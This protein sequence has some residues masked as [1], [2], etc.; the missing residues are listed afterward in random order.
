M[1][2]PAKLR[3]ATSNIRM[4]YQTIELDMGTKKNEG[5]QI[6]GGGCKTGYVIIYIY[7]SVSKCMLNYW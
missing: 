7:E 6:D 5:L 2:V 3:I 1:I 4:Q